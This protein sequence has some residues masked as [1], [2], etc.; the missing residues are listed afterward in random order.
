MNLAD[1]PIVQGALL[2]FGSFKQLLVGVSHLACDA[3]S[4]DILKE[5]IELALSQVLLRKEIRLPLKTT[6]FKYWAE[7]LHE[8][9]WSEDFHQELGY[10]SNLDWKQVLPVPLDYPDNSSSITMGSGA[11]VNI[12]FSAGKTRALMRVANA[13]YCSISDVLLV[14]LAKAIGEW[15]GTRTVL[16]DTVVNGRQPLFSE[17]D[18]S[19]TVG[20]LVYRRPVILDVGIGAENEG[21]L[22]SCVQQMKR[23]PSGV[24]VR[25]CGSGGTGPPR[26]S[27]A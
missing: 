11:G 16:I 25:S 21:V 6:S 3:M 9:T 14:A 17:I 20:Y 4:V 1:G 7:R 12:L 18:L 13:N 26:R 24:I 15:S 10:W 5:D 22:R 8:Y 2:N 23:V 27:T 19:R